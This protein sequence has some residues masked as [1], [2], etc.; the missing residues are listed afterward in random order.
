MTPKDTPLEA[1]GEW[2]EAVYN[3][4]ENWTVDPHQH[5][6]RLIRVGDALLAALR[7]SPDAQTPGWPGELTTYEFG[8]ADAFG[9]GVYVALADVKPEHRCGVRGFADS[10]DKCPACAL[11]QSPAPDARRETSPTPGRGAN[12]GPA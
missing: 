3:A 8:D 9:R 7:S 5:I 1:R 12:D 2:D 4:R 6:E 11:R 10:G